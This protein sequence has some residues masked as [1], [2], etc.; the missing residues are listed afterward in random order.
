MP[1]L[2]QVT[3]PSRL[4]FGLWSLGGDTAGRQ[5]GGV[6]AMIEQPGLKLELAPA[7]RFAA[8][9]TLAERMGV[10]ARRWASFHRAALPACEMRLLAAPPEHVGLGT[11]TQLGLAVAAGLNAWSGWPPLSPVELA[12]SVGRGLRSAVGT[13]GFVYGGLVVEQGK[14]PGEPISPLDCRVD[15][16][17]H[18]RFVLARPIGLTGLAGEDEAEA[19]ASLPAIAGEIHAELVREVREHLVPT[20][21][22]HDFDEFAASLYRYGNLSGGCFAARQGGPY[23]GPV[24]TA[25]VDRIRS[26]GHAGVGQS[27][28]GPTLFALA[29]DQKSA[30]TLATELRS[31]GQFGELAVAVTA[32]CNSGA[33]VEVTDS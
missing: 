30:E 18:W 19:I 28:W 20:A 15:L 16:P 32:P 3:A 10:F 2:V 23:S 4:H 11:G 33:R 1:R 5:F 29:R 14:L 21:A 9:G 6:G 7:D 17:A 13:Y 8:S 31:E 22:T 26:L 12:L 25:L 24:L 27:S